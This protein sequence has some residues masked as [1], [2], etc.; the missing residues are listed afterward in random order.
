MI[1]L[2]ESK[3]F[4]PKARGRILKSMSYISFSSE[5]KIDIEL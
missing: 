3:L 2:F 4:K 5:K 1:E